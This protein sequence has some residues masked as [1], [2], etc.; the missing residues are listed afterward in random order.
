M[1]QPWEVFRKVKRRHRDLRNRVSGVNRS[2]N[3]QTST[4]SDLKFGIS[5]F[6]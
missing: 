4:I 1:Q 5:E 3:G 6:N 2:S